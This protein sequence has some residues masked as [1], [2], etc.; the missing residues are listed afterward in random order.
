MREGPPEL[1][2]EGLILTTSL[3]DRW[4]DP[5]QGVH[6]QAPAQLSWDAYLLAGQPFIVRL[7]CVQRNKASI[8]G[9]SIEQRGPRVITESS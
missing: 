6:R 7:S 8:A 9:V 2:V 1:H 5:A 4:R 3:H